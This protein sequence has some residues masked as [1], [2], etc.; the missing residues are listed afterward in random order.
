M[1]S[2]ALVAT[3]MAVAPPAA[4][5]TYSGGGGTT[6]V[7]DG[8][9]TPLSLDISWSGTA[10][11]SQNFAGLLMRARPGQPARPVY[12]APDGAELGAVS[13]H[14]GVVTFATTSADGTETALMTRNRRG[15]VRTLASLSDHEV[16]SNPDGDA[17]YGVTDLAPSCEE[18]WPADMLGP[19]SYTG[20]VESH[21]YASL[22][23]RRGTRYVADA[24]G[25]TIVA[26]AKGGSVSTAAVLPPQPAEI[27]AEAASMLGIPECAVGHTYNFEPVP[28]D[29]EKGRGGQLYVT[30]LPGGPEDPSL[31][32]R[33]SVWKVNPHTGA[34]RRVAKGL[35][36][37]TGLAVAHNGDLYVA[38]LFNNR[39][40][41]IPRGSSRPTRWRNATM[42]GD[43]EIGKGD[44]WAT[45][46]V[47]VEPPAGQVVRY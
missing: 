40:A 24:A 2:L 37:A 8:L 26:V 43:V 44:V 25:N 5:G 17:V 39:I 10:W 18:E 7:A 30:L 23:V 35:L 32:A 22:T 47:L 36:G 16:S 19:P 38:E 29:V 41:R 27:T 6:V 9:V 20:I 33:A 15:H 14:R 1:A 11:F 46:Q 21:P 31:G 13:F 28:T 3:P 34:S 4:G 45:R 12:Q 42:P